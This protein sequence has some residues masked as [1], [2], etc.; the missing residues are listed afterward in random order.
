MIGQ[1][2]RGNGIGGGVRLDHGDQHIGRGEDIGIFLEG[3]ERQQDQIAK[4][5]LEGGLAQIFDLRPFGGDDDFDVLALAANSRAA[6]R[7][8][9]GLCFRPSVPV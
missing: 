6:A 2:L 3:L 9:S 8:R 4:P 7:I 5:L 1:D